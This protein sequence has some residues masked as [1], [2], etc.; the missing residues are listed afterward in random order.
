MPRWQTK[1]SEVV[2][3]TP[4]MTVKRNEVRNHAGKDLVYSFIELSHPSVSIVAINEAGNILIQREYRYLIDKEV[5]AMPAGH[6]D[7][8]DLLVAAK[9]E[10]LEEAG[11]VSDDW[12]D[13]GTFYQLIGMGNVPFNVFIARNV[14]PSKS[15]EEETEEILE[16]TFKPLR[17]IEQMIAEGSFP[18]SLVVTTLYAAKVNGIQ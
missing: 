16:R 5:W 12:T 1:S 3:K 14:K 9:R 18:D 11:M 6:S 10:L 17:E 2:Y 15:E 4:W 13:V 8:D 7:G